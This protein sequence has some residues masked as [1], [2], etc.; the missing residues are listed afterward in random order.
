MVSAEKKTSPDRG[1][2]P[3][4]VIHHEKSEGSV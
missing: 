4:P 2:R 1:E 3:C